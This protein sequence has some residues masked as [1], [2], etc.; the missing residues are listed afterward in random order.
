MPVL[1]STKEVSKIILLWAAIV[2]I[3]LFIAWI[4]LSFYGNCAGNIDLSGIPDID[5]AQYQFLIMATGEIIYTDSYDNPK[6]GKYIIHGWY[7]LVD[8]KY[9][10][11]EDDLTL[12]V[13]Y[14]GEIRVKIR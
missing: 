8:K 3:I 4:G 14:F 10:W 6:E 12:D 7:E 2:L 13:Y 9:R 1:H 11:H 5:K